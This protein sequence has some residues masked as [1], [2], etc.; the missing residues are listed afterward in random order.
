MNTAETTVTITQQPQQQG[1]LETVKE[2][3]NINQIVDKVHESRNIIV[4][5]ALYG[6]I[7]FLIG[8]LLK[9]YSNAVIVVILMTTALIIM[10][11]F[12]ILTMVIHWEKINELLGLPVASKLITDNFPA[13]AME[14]ARTNVPI[15]VSMLVGFLVGI[16]VG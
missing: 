14:W 2:K 4:D 11:Q 7:G 3:V 5:I 12:D 9:R 1:L 16:R 10:Q 8:Y 6:G 15:V 13:L